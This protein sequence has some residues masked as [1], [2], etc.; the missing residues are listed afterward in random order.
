MK[1]ARTLA[2]VL[3]LAAAALAAG[4][5]THNQTSLTDDVEMTTSPANAGRISGEGDLSAAYHGLGATLMMTDADGIWGVGPGPEGKLAF[6]VGDQYAYIGSPKD[7]RLRGV[8]LDPQS[9]TFSADL[10]ELNIS[11]PIAALTPG[12]TRALEAVEG[13][14][15]T[16]AEARIEQMRIAGEITGD[17]ADIVL[18]VI[19][20]L[21]PTS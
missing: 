4:C 21:L 5:G 3:T 7:A 14:T 6:P 11:E 18:R 15:I 13:M 19:V 9:G 2:L 17:V 10:I 8:E 12:L 16:E 20:P 1:H